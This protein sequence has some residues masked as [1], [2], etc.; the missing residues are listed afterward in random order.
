MHLYF[1]RN[2]R[3]VS[4]RVLIVDARVVTTAVMILTNGGLAIS[5]IK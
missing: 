3:I 4:V 5:N 2:T 1:A